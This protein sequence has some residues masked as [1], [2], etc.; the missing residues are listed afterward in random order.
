MKIIN[1]LAGLA[2]AISSFGQPYEAEIEFDIKNGGRIVTG[3]FSDFQGEIN[4]DPEKPETSYIKG[5]VASSGINTGIGMRDRHLQARSYFHSDKYPL[6]SMESKEISSEGDG[7]FRAK[8]SL[9]IKETTGIV[10][11]PFSLSYTGGGREFSGTFSMNRLDWKV[12]NKS[13]FID[14]EVMVRVR[15]L[16]K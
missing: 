16:E 2:I 11:V 14:Q 10:E 8:F 9:T 4:F 5:S 3:S 1:I 12:G 6:I 7:Q 15:I 13:L